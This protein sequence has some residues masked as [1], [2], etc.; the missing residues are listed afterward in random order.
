M[1]IIKKRRRSKVEEVSSELR[2]HFYKFS[3]NED[4]FVTLFESLVSAIVKQSIEIIEYNFYSLKIRNFSYSREIDQIL[5]PITTQRVRHCTSRLTIDRVGNASERTQSFLL[6]IRHEL[7]Y[8]LID[9]RP[10][11]YVQ[12]STIGV[13]VQVCTTRM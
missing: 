2:R 11:L 5:S 1:I 6:R 4:A 13:A 10:E 12:S 8:L 9:R 7:F 3:Q